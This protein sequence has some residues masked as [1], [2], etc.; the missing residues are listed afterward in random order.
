MAKSTLTKGNKITSKLECSKRN[1]RWVEKK[2]GKPRCRLLP[3]K[4]GKK[5]K[6]ITKQISNIVSA[7]KNR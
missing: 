3:G 1:G 7:I 4:A 2:Y 6:K 5:P